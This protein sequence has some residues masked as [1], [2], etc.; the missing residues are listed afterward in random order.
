MHSATSREK[1]FPSTSVQQS[2]TARFGDEERTSSCLGN[3]WRAQSLA[4]YAVHVNVRVI[5]GQGFLEEIPDHGRFG[6]SSAIDGKKDRVGRVEGH[7]VVQL[8]GARTAA[9]IGD[10]K[11]WEKSLRY[12]W[13]EM[14]HA[15]V[16]CGL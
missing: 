10:W 4:G 7:N 6:E 12:F 14:K 2:A 16:H 8:F 3:R 5:A 1:D 9:T 11:K 15:S 13:V